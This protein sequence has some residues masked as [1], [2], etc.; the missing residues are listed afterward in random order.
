WA[1]IGPPLAVASTAIVVLVLD[2]F[3]PARR[4]SVTVGTAL[5]GLLVGLALMLPLQGASRG[6]FCLDEA[7]AACSYVVDDVTLVFWLVAAGGAIVVVLL[8]TVRGAGLPGGEYHFF[9]LASATGAMTI[10][11]A[12]DLITLVV[13]LEL[14][15]LPA[16]ALVGLRRGS[17]RAAEAALKF[18]LVSVVSVAVMLFGIAL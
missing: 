2:G 18:F 5:L 15:T 6:V 11:A 17:G 3:L 14:V 16:I 9:V 4:R 13:A 7:G 12:R 8:S 10:A 1:A